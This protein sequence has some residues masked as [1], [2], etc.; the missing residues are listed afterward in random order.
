LKA[1]YLV[2]DK[3]KKEKKRTL[4]KRTLSILRKKSRFGVTFILFPGVCRSVN[5]KKT[6]NYPDEKKKTKTFN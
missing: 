2:E 3:K 5:L 6:F 1:L 4:S